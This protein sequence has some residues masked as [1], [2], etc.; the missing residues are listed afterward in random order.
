MYDIGGIGIACWKRR[1]CG[2]S[3]AARRTDIQISMDIPKVRVKVRV[4]VK[5]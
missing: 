2:K 4:R 1:A 5:G 3:L